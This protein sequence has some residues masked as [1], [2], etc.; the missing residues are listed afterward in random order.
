MREVECLSEVTQ[1]GVVAQV[2]DLIL[3]MVEQMIETHR[4]TWFESR[5][6]HKGNRGG[7]EQQTGRAVTQGYTLSISLMVC[8]AICG[9]PDKVVPVSNNGRWPSG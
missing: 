3:P 1:Y 4:A 9:I 7:V 5:L 6:H 2:E 8:E